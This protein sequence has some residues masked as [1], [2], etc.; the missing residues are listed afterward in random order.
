MLIARL[1]TRAAKPNGQRLVQAEE[2][3]EVGLRMQMRVRMCEGVYTFMS[4]CLLQLMGVEGTC[5]CSAH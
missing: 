5:T 3:R 1:A 2:A 4:Y